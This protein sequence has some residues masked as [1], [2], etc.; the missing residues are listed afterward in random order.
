MISLDVSRAIE[1]KTLLWMWERP[2]RMPNAYTKQVG[3]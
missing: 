3:G 1:M 2:E